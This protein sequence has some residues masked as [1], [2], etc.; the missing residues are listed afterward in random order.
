MHV[1]CSLVWGGTSFV[2]RALSQFGPDLLE[3]QPWHQFGRSDN[4]ANK[5]WL[6]L[7]KSRKKHICALNSRLSSHSS[8]FG[9]SSNIAV[10]AICLCFLPWFKIN[11]WFGFDPF[12]RSSRM[13]QIVLAMSVELLLGKSLHS[14]HNDSITS[15]LWT[16]QYILDITRLCGRLYYTKVQLLVGSTLC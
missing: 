15:N 13:I 4:T 7:A 1:R 5:D 11:D 12:S 9:I 14:S 16:T 3:R 8:T 10:I 2:T 6:T